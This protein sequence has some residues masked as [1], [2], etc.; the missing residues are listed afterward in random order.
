MRT[1]ISRS[2]KIGSESAHDDWPDVG[3]TE[4]DYLWFPA[5]LKQLREDSPPRREPLPPFCWRLR[6]KPVMGCWTVVYI[7]G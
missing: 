6:G 1:S 4:G 7:P 3:I 2:V 5:L